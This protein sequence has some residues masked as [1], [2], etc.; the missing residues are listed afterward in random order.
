MKITLFQNWNL[1]FTYNKSKPQQPWPKTST[2]QSDFKIDEFQWLYPKLAKKVQRDPSFF[3]ICSYTFTSIYRCRYL[4][5]I[6]LLRFSLFFLQVWSVYSISR[7]RYESF[8]HFR[9]QW[10]FHK[11]VHGMIGTFS[12]LFALNSKINFV[13]LPIFYPEFHRSS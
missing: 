11:R 3:W 5:L 1:I 12:S 10:I 13:G 6:Y 9:F 8:D 4:Y 2:A 7:T